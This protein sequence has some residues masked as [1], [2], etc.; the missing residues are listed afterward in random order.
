VRG[1]I[2]RKYRSVA[3]SASGMFSYPTGRQG[4]LLLGYDGDLLR[5]LPDA[6]LESFC[7][8]GNP[9][10]IAPVR[11]GAAI[12]DIGCGAGF[13]LLVAAKISGP[14]GVVRGVDLT[15]EMVERA[16]ANILLAGVDNIE[17]RETADD[18]LPFV[19]DL[20]DL[21]ISNGVINLS[22]D[23][24]GLFAEIFRVLKTGGKLQFADIVLE[25]EL[26]RHLDRSVESWS[27]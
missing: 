7:G 4:A 12:L 14:G 5:S 3:R 1:G 10:A 22:P 9:L 2:R 8:V 18:R 26:P 19:D 15:P 27:Q 13:D 25:K 11:P 16:R 17:V 23:K 21:V 24:P 6:V 20:F